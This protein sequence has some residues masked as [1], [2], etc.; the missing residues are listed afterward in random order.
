MKFRRLMRGGVVPVALSMSLLL[1]GCGVS[2]KDT[3][4]QSAFMSRYEALNNGNLSAG[5]DGWHRTFA[6]QSLGLKPYTGDT[7]DLDNYVGLLE[8]LLAGEDA[9]LS[10]LVMAD[11]VAESFR[12]ILDRFKLTNGTTVSYECVGDIYRVTRTYDGSKCAQMEFPDGIE[13]CALPGYYRQLADGRWYRDDLM[14]V[15]C[16]GAMNAYCVENQITKQFSFDVETGSLLITDGVPREVSI[17]LRADGRGF[18]YDGQEVE[19]QTTIDI[20]DF[21]TVVDDGADE[22]EEGDSASEDE[23]DA[24]DAD[25][26]GTDGGTGSDI[27]MGVTDL[28]ELSYDDYKAFINKVTDSGGT[29]LNTFKDIPVDERIPEDSRLTVPISA[30]LDVVGIPGDSISTANTDIFDEVDSFGGRGC[31]AGAGTYAIDS[32]VKGAYSPDAKVVVDYYLR[33][34]DSGFETIGV[35]V[36]GYDCGVAQTI[37]NMDSVACSGV[38]WDAIRE[39]CMESDRAFTNLDLISI[40]DGSIYLD[41]GYLA[42]AVFGKEGMIM[43]ETLTTPQRVVAFDSDTATYVVAADRTFASC[44]MDGGCVGRYSEDMLIAIRFFDD[45]PRIIDEYGYDFNLVGDPYIS[46]MSYADIVDEGL[47]RYSA[48]VDDEA[49]E[50]IK[51][52]LTIFYQAQNDKVMSVSTAEDAERLGYSLGIKTVFLDG[53]PLLSADQRDLF[54]DHIVDRITYSGGKS[55]VAGNIVSYMGSTGTYVDVMVDDTYDYGSF[56]ITDTVVYSFVNTAE[57]WRICDMDII[58]TEK[59]FR[60]GTVAASTGTGTASQDAAPEATAPEA[61]A[62]PEGN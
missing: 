54:V 36:N 3:T 25:D 8:G 26:G 33:R 49:K 61:T 12:Y 9:N 42:K 47:W 11:S 18:I 5:D 34:T 39:I 30:I 45:G 58:N 52:L 38:V 37:D 46:I 50:G 51:E 15:L 4:P 40:G 59:V 43:R 28:V 41:K 31:V 22:G 24:A 20:S 55:V 6:T 27:S 23:A 35:L 19:V 56:S 62:A 7:T 17:Q 57:G 60:D 16:V 2:Y 21:I 53:D 14:A 1:S 10:S 48:E 44:D 29:V 13:Y 32:L